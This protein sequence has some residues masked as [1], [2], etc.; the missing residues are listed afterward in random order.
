MAKE[1]IKTASRRPRW[2][3]MVAWL[4]EARE[5]APDRDHKIALAMSF[6]M[7]GLVTLINTDRTLHQSSSA[8]ISY[9]ASQHGWPMI[10]LKREFEADLPNHLRHS[11]QYDWPYPAVA[12]EGRT[13]SVLA[14]VVDIITALAITV[15]AY[16]LIRRLVGSFTNPQT[17]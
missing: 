15:T 3:S 5:T 1:S 2:R 4:L 9:Q 10:Y 12:G 8:K 11:R 17:Q 13:L 16:F 7:L 14:L 6:L